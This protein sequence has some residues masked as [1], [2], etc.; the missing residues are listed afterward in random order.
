MSHSWSGNKRKMG[1]GGRGSGSSQSWHLA[2]GL[3]EIQQFQCLEADD[4]SILRKCDSF[5]S[6]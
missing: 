5:F 6:A 1:F 4:P 3:I 2:E